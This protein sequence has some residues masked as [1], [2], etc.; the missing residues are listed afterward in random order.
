MP[1]AANAIVTTPTQDEVLWVGHVADWTPD[2]AGRVEV[3]DG[4][5]VAQRV[6]VA[7]VRRT[8]TATE[9]RLRNSLQARI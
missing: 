2:D 5:G 1:G 3:T 9:D 7:C 8:A 6:A 4:D